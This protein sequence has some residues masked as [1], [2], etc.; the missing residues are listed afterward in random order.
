[1]R[2][3]TKLIAAG[4]VAAT[5]TAMAVIPALADPP[6]GVTP[7]AKDITGVG[8]DTI[9]NVLAQFSVD[10]NKS[11]KASAP[12]LYSWNA[13][14]PVTGVVHDMITAKS[15]C[16][17]NER[18]NGSSEGITGLPLSLT[19][20]LKDNKKP[21]TGFC[22]DFSRSSRGRATTD[23]ADIQFVPFALDA[24]TFATN[25]GSNAPSDLTAAQLA[26]IYECHITNWK[27][28][29]GKSG[30]I[31]AQLPQSGSG[32][33]KFFLTALGNGTPI[34]PGACVDSAKG[35]NANNLPEENEGISPFLKGANTIYPYSVGDWIAQVFHSAPGSSKGTCTP[36]RG[37]NEFS[38]DIH[39]NMQLREINRTAPLQFVG[40]TVSLDKSFDSVFQRDVFVVVRLAAHEPGGVPGYL[41]ALFGPH[42]WLFSSKAA[43][44][45]ILNY[46]FLP[47]H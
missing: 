9:Q 1:M 30:K 20:N 35:E 38:C 26:G 10:Y 45:D 15:G 13:T 28:V 18:P 43:H 24:V 5:A 46:G 41:Q 42:G 37:Q 11:V 31:N 33:L 12:H 2:T 3:F 23:P 36:G 7:R 39:G 32:T 4:A 16:A 29:G 14:N 27:Q 17:K 22:T 25:A 6:K 47:L 40:K 21:G 44:N 19:S 34:T 8:S